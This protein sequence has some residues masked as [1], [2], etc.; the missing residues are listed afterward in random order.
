MLP[1]AHK[2]QKPQIEVLKTFFHLKKNFA[3]CLWL[4]FFYSIDY[5]RLK[6][7]KDGET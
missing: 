3:R 7:K 2:E 1:S 4:V 6:N 5:L